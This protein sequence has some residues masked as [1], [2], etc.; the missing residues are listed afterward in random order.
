MTGVLRKRRS[1]TVAVLAVAT[2]ATALLTGC[3]E[4]PEEVGMPTEST[5]AGGPQGSP[6]GVRV[7]PSMPVSPPDRPVPSG[8]SRSRPPVLPPPSGPPKTPS[9][10]VTSDWIVGTVTTD[11]SGPCHG[12]VTDDGRE[13]AMHSTAGIT[14]RR[15]TR[16]RVQVTPSRLRIDCGPGQQVTLVR[17]EVLG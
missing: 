2:F 8:L 15:N 9:D 4:R 16:I 14:L 12:L 6:D 13:Y 3:A 10:L 1:R 11:G 17:A 7:D 5:S